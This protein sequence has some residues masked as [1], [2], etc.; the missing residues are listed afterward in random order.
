MDIKNIDLNMDLGEGMG[1]D[2]TVMP[3]ITSCNVACGGHYG[4]YNTIKKTL[5][6][7]QKHDVKVG[8]HP[9]F[10]DRE[11]F[12]RVHLNWDEYRF[13]ESVTKQIELVQQ[14]CN[15]LDLTLSHI[16]M[17]GALYHATANRNDF[18]SWTIKLLKERFPLIT[19]FVP[20]QSVLHKLMLEEQLLFKVEAFA[21]RR[22][23]NDGSLVSRNEDTAVI[24]D[25]AKVVNQLAM[26]VHQRQVATIEEKHIDIH[27]RTY[28][29]HGDNN[30][31]LDQFSDLK[32]QLLLNHITI[33]S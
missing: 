18:A 12:G 23:N 8:A 21:D 19:L 10:E 31:L 3:F 5:L 14:V 28:C 26:M 24:T 1:N 9:S 32:K 6:I 15:E 16:K 7:A 29:I 11:N 17:H 30:L 25:V 4:D 2:A 27:A 20:Y 22:Y 13:C 33:E